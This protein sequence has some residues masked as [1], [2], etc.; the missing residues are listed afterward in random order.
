MHK[1]VRFNARSWEGIQFPLSVKVISKAFQFFITL[2]NLNF[3]QIKIEPVNGLL[4]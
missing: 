4:L 3:F 2:I 1:R